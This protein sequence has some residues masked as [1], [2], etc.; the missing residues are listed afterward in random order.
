[1]VFTHL[2]I[3]PS[4]TL[5]SEPSLS[6]TMSWPLK[7][8]PASQ[9][10]SFGGRDKALYPNG[11]V[12]FDQAVLAAGDFCR[13]YHDRNSGRSPGRENELFEVGGKK[14]ESKKAESTSPGED[15]CASE[16]PLH[17]T[18]SISYPKSNQVEESRQRRFVENL[19]RGK[20]N[21]YRRQYSSKS[22]YEA[23]KP[24]NSL[25]TND[26]A[27]TFYH[28]PPFVPYLTLSHTRYATFENK[29]PT[30]LNPKDPTIEGG[31][32]SSISLPANPAAIY[33]TMEKDL[34]IVSI[35]HITSEA[36]PSTPTEK[37]CSPQSRVEKEQV[38]IRAYACPR[39]AR[40]VIKQS[41]FQKLLHPKDNIIKPVIQLAT[42]VFC[43]KHNK[44]Q[45]SEKQPS[46]AKEVLSKGDVKELR[47]TRGYRSLFSRKWVKNVA[48]AIEK[49]KEE[50][51][52]PEV[53]AL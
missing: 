16:T 23:H 26:R 43:L 3:H 31:E 19:A 38:P 10:I 35:D 53:V 48:Q 13:T 36:K 22:S 51:K 32:W 42:E 20:W 14:V 27:S 41:F 37:P 9:S 33:H 5:R 44:M 21:R 2:T 12:P 25:S 49:G 46:D 11:L 1:M 4:I 50:K 47:A 24:A 39:Q 34:V 28:F 52:K 6:A 17:N 40:F 7:Y 18:A 8:D 29:V 15:R 45:Q 30:D